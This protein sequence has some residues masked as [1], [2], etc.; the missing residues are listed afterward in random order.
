MTHESRMMDLHS[1]RGARAAKAPS[2]LTDSPLT[3]GKRTFPTPS[4]PACSPK[5]PE[6]LRFSSRTSGVRKMCEQTIRANRRKRR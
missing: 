5:N 4:S 3:A 1:R 6:R 2:A